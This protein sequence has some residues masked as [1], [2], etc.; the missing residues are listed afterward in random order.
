M[1]AFTYSRE[2]G[3]A[4]YSFAHQVP[5]K[6]KKKRLDELMAL[7]KKISYENNKK[8]IG[9][10]MEGLVVSCDSAHG[11]YGLRS[12]W[13]APD[14]IDGSIAFTSKKPLKIGE[15]VQ[16]KITG[17]FVYDLMGEALE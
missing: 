17:A 5:E 15:V 3:T 14:D 1:G 16:V 12:R 10:V 7:Q 8:R 13:N 6:T 9:E 4:A 2:E 11:L